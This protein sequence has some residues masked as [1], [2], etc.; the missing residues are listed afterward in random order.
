MT[1][2]ARLTHRAGRRKPLM[3]PVTPLVDSI[4]LHALVLYD[5][6]RR[7]S[8]W[9]LRKIPVLPHCCTR[10]E[11]I[12]I[13]LPSMKGSWSDKFKLMDLLKYKAV[14]YEFQFKGLQEKWAE[15]ARVLSNA[16]KFALDKCMCNTTTAC[17]TFLCNKE[18][19]S[20]CFWRS[21]SNLFWHSYLWEWSFQFK[22]CFCWTGSEL[23]YCLVSQDLIAGRR[24]SLTPPQRMQR[25]LTR[26]KNSLRK[27]WNIVLNAWYQTFCFCLLANAWWSNE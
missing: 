19:T 22:H 24:K 21:S 25:F 26:D 15:V 6:A 4:W 16:E 20:N 13:F 3:S 2:V 14:N 10:G 9:F 23:S 17:P 18:V 27:M 12:S 8:A 5:T 11:Q 1:Y 7:K